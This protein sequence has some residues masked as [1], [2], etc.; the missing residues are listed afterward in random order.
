MSENALLLF[1]KPSHP[2]RVKTRLIG[3][4]T[5]EEAAQLHGAFRDDL[6]EHLSGAAFHLAVA[7]AL[8]DDEDVPSAVGDLEL[9]GFRQQ[10]EDLGAR[11]FNALHHTAERFERVGAV[12]S[13]HPELQSAIVEDAFQR[14]AS[15]ADIVLGPAADGG[16]YLIALRREA[17][18]SELFEDIAWSTQTVLAQ[19]LAHAKRLGLSIDLLDIGHDID[20]AE[21]L[22]DLAER[23]ATSDADC[24]RTRALL[25]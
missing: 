13:D 5:P 7:W 6:A 11:L 12:G 19:T 21:D 2:G 10:G 15:G 24:P 16:Y 1:T 14:L 23:L 4:L 25:T 3:E 20:H 22:R 8:D 17:L 18:T 9:P